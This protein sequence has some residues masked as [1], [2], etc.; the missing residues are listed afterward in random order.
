MRRGQNRM[1][2]A[3][4]VGLLKKGDSD[5]VTDSL[6]S[7]RVKRCGREAVALL[8][9]V[10]AAAPLVSVPHVQESCRELANESRKA[11]RKQ[12]FEQVLSGDLYDESFEGSTLGDAMN[13]LTE[14]RYDRRVQNAQK[15]KYMRLQEKHAASRRVQNA[16]ASSLIARQYSSACMPMF[17]LAEGIENIYTGMSDVD[18]DRQCKKR[19]V[20]SERYVHQGL[21]AV[22]AWVPP[23]KLKYDDE[24]SRDH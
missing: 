15:G 22:G 5:I 14:S 12:L 19:L 20:P 13:Q 10:A 1:A 2:A 7:E 18:W 17:S 4:E 16:A 23:L 6:T 11:G 24:P 3:Q 8:D 9:R 21:E